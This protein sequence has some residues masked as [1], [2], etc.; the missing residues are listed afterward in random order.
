MSQTQKMTAKDIV[1]DLSPELQ[2]E[3][4]SL[5]NGN[6]TEEAAVGTST[7]GEE[8]AVVG[9]SEPVNA[10][11]ASTEEDATDTTQ[12][13]QESTDESSDE[14][15]LAKLK[16]QRKR[17]FAEVNKLKA[18]NEKM[19]A[20][21]AEKD[22][23]I[24]EAKELAGE[25][26]SEDKIQK[27]INDV[28]EKQDFIKQYQPSS[29]ELDAIKE[30]KSSTGLKWEEA[31]LLHTAKTNPL[32]LVDQTAARKAEAKPAVEGSQPNINQ[33]AKE[34]KD[35]SFDELYKLAS[36]ANIHKF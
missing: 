22:K 13:P 26:A 25:D 35:M 33:P 1:A 36:Q 16:E 8:V 3:Y 30:I 29:D 9:N 18:E 28:F 19:L 21:K 20:E 32:M 5:A 34:A 27:S 17:M 31:A 4:N 11:E 2:A 7:A 6:Q 23:L 24:E 12:E 10:M 15:Q 14:D